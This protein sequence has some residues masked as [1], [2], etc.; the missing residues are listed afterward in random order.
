M[1][2]KS[3]GR[4]ILVLLSLTLFAILVLMVFGSDL[5]T[6]HTPPHLD[7]LATG[8]SVKY[9]NKEYTDVTIAQ[10][11]DSG[12]SR[13]DIVT[14]SRTIEP[15]G[16]VSPTLMFKSKHAAVDVY[17]DGKIIY[18]FGREE[19]QSGKFVPKVYNMVS[20]EDCTVPHELKIN[21]VIAEDNVV[22]GFFPVY[23]GTKKEL[24]TY[25][26][27]NHRLSMFI[28]SFFWIYAAILFTLGV[29][30]FLQKRND[31]SYFVSAGL[32]LILGM[33]TFSYNDILCFVS[34]KNVLFSDFEY[35]SLYLLPL[36]VL[37]LL[38]VTHPEIAPGLQN[39]FIV[40]NVS[41]P[42]VFFMTHFTGLV[43]FPHYVGL[44][45]IVTAI[46]NVVMLPALIVGLKEEYNKENENKLYEGMGAN[47]YLVLGYIILMLFVF[48]EIMRFN[49]TNYD[50]DSE[51]SFF[52]QVTLLDLGLFAFVICLFLYYFINS[53]DHM[54]AT[55][56]KKELE[57]LA[58]TDALT[59]LMNRAKC[60]QFAVMLKVP[61]GL[62][63]LDLDRLKK[64]NDTYGHLEGDKMIKAFADLLKNTF[65]D[66]SLIGR[67]GGDEFMVI[68]ENP[69]EEKCEKS[70]SLLEQ[71]V[72]EYNESEGAKQKFTLSASAGY[73]YSKEI[74]KK[75]FKFV[76]YLADTRMYKMKETH[77]A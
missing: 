24:I 5:F 67:T 39:A 1:D 18:S 4:N 30:L 61:Y 44:Y 42:L 53:V 8:W 68:F 37:V 54:N 19:Y 28:G 45:Q 7:Q 62:I 23:L 64:V 25:F 52:Y 2:R 33:Y 22:K 14:F 77:H 6:T 11:G 15:V 51:S 46:E 73:A 76:Y 59:G 27:Q 13:G 50:T 9:G 55:K 41:M 21:Y 29:Y 75:D 38:H 69:E 3:K 65:T 34:D 40:I 57:G 58:Y 12:Y 48:L 35:I 17:I 72:R 16:V 60:T 47:N 43:H 32:S 74:E 56:V 63:N 26:F 49:I 70:I 66:A 31:N 20:I 71:K 36:A 10:I